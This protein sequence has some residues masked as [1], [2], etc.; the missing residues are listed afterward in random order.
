[1]KCAAHPDVETDLRCGK[2]GRPICPRCMV[3][4][5]VGARCPDC[6][7]VRRLPTYEVS[8]RHYL[9]AAGV[10][11]GVAAA[12][13]VCWALLWGLLPHLYLYLLLAAAAGYA[14][15][16]LVSL[17]I[18][19]KRG[20]GLQAIAASCMVVSFGIGFLF[21]H[22]FSYYFLL[23]LALGIILAVVRLR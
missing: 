11:L 13:G 6:A 23:G 17:S 14:I 9:I 16:E 5:P 3:Q 10:G 21:I 18:N 15:G 7:K 8:A 4:T 2:C 19:R 12:V 20:R 22:F 1:M